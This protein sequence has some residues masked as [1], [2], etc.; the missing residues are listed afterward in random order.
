MSEKK[1]LMEG[2]NER[3]P[4]REITPGGFVY[5][6]GNS[7]FFNTGDWRTR[8]PA[9]REDKC[10]QCLLCFPVCPDSS[11]PVKDGKRGDFD[12]GHCKGCAIC[13][14]VCPFGAIDVTEGTA[15][16]PAEQRNGGA[17]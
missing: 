9:W 11:I 6:S 13:A 7:E 10:R 5:G 8:T 15:P 14:K 4:W 2:I 16:R 17:Q 12:F 3:S 1:N